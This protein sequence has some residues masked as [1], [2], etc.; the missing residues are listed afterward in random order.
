MDWGAVVWIVL[1]ILGAGLIFGGIVAYRG[2]TKSSV[3][4][5]SA[6]AM[7]SGL[8]MWAVIGFTVPASTSSDNAESPAPVVTSNTV[9]SGTYE[10]FTEER[11]AALLTTDDVGNV[12]D[13]DHTL[14]LEFRDGRAMAAGVDPSQVTEIESWYTV[15]FQSDNPIRGMTFSVMDFSSANSAQGHFDNVIGETPGLVFMDPPI[16]DISAHVV[17]NGQGLGSIVMYRHQ[18]LFVSLHTAQPFGVEVLMPVEKLEELARLVL[19]RVE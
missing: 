6:A 7:A 10:P 11:V 1:G 2:S 17:F 16:G 15:A 9:P 18:D 3:R 8:A 13:G 14:N 5:A 12:A 4:A 19:S